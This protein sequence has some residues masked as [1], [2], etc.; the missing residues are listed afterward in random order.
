M[1]TIEGPRF[2]TR[3]ES[4]MFKSFGGDVINMTTVPEVESTIHCIIND[5]NDFKCSD[6]LVFFLKGPPRQRG[7]NQLRFSCHGH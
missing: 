3:A 5:V 1:V 2:S 4:I 7:W 6:F